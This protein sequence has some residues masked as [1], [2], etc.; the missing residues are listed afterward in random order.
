M[1]DAKPIQEAVAAG[2]PLPEVGYVEAIAMAMAMSLVL[3]NIQLIR[4]AKTSPRAIIGLE[5]GFYFCIVAF[6][7]A[8]TTL[9]ASTLTSRF[10]VGLKDYFP[11]ISAFLGVFGFESI[12]KNTNVTMFDRGVLTIQ[13]WTERALT[14]AGAAAIAR[15]Q[16][17]DSRRQ[18]LVVAILMNFANDRL[19]ALVLS[20]L[21]DKVRD[22]EAAA[23]ANQADPKRYKAMQLAAAYS[24]PEAQ[25]L[26]LD[27]GS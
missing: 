6:G 15:Q 25:A 14:V 20:K 11:F 13:D 10:P 21:G 26:I 4:E 23:V 8:A 19:N 12:L 24:I 7:Y 27:H 16:R 9:L 3:A 2:A 18:A 1:G 17:Y 22:L 5:L